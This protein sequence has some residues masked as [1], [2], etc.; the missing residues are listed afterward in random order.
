M[1]RDPGVTSLLVA[2]R[3]GE[4]GSFERLFEVVYEDLKRRAH[5]QISSTPHTLN[6]TGLLHEAYVKLAGSESQDWAD[7]QHFYRVAARAMRQIV[8]DRARERV[9]QKRGGG[10]VPADIDGIQVGV[11]SAADQM[12]ALDQALSR[13]GEQDHRLAQVVELRFFG[14]LSVEDTARTL[15]I[16][17]R[18]VKRDWR[19]A[20]AFLLDALS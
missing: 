17:P 6:T 10:L 11:E 3:Q 4:A 16:S 12:V 8:I 14:G 2:V 7:G 9:A 19:L 13:L 1:K 15:D 5:Y 18:T 20:R